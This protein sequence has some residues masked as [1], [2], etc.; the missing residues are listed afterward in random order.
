MPSSLSSIFLSSRDASPLGISARATSAR[1]TRSTCPLDP[2][3]AKRRFLY[4]PRWSFT[5]WTLAAAWGRVE[6]VQCR[7]TSLARA[8][9]RRT[10]AVRTRSRA[11]GRAAGRSWHRPTGGHQ[12]PSSGLKQYCRPRSRSGPGY[13]QERLAQRIPEAPSRLLLQEVYES[14]SEVT[15]VVRA[16]PRDVAKLDMGLWESGRSRSA[17]ESL[18]APRGQMGRDSSSGGDGTRGNKLK[19]GDLD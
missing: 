1:A 7:R 19:E 9:V 16:Q 8:L 10:G 11:A 5:H 15:L 2:S 12:A 3:Y 4:P 6:K 14:P 13:C 17:Q 18:N